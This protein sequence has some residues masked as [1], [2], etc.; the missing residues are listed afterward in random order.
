MSVECFEMLRILEPKVLDVCEGVEMDQFCWKQTKTNEDRLTFSEPEEIWDCACLIWQCMA[1][2][3]Q[4]LMT[5]IT[6]EEP[7]LP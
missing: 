3:R 5:L 1:T 7:A 2:L 6:N 4:V